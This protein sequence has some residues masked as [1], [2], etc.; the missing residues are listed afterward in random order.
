M[1][2]K[3]AP[4]GGD[5]DARAGSPPVTDQPES[6]F[7]FRPVKEGEDLSDLMEIQYATWG[8]EDAVVTHQIIA[9]LKNGG[10]VIGAYLGGRMA[11]FSY[12]FPGFKDGQVYLCSHMLAVLPEYRNS[13]LGWQLKLAQRAAALEK[14]YT[15]ITWTYDPLQ[16]PNA[17]LNLGKLKAFTRTYVVDYYGPMADPINAGIP[18]DRFVVE[19]PLRSPRVLATVRHTAP[20]GPA[21]DQGTA[22]P[23]WTSAPKVNEMDSSGRGSVPNL[24]LTA[25]Q[26]TVVIPGRFQQLKEANLEE[27]R[28]WRQLTREIFLHYF[29]RG[30]V[31][32][33]FWGDKHRGYYLLE[34]GIDLTII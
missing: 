3:N 23:S 16:A 21:T 8:R 9:A 7:S 26:I 5:S 28:R 14:G 15:L 4:A 24:S 13:G 34:R 32:T 31:A 12:G 29:Q 11:G 2:T 17:R 27:A 18:S 19:W 20:P 25:P 30:Y 22:R 6:P 33:D 1:S 10:L